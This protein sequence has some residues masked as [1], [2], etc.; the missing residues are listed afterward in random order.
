MAPTNI[1]QP[2]TLKAIR[3]A[4]VAEVKRLHSILFPLAYRDSYFSDL[5]QS[6]SLSFMS[7]HPFE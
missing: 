6:N 2:V 7:M 3:A 4:D 5:L 1:G